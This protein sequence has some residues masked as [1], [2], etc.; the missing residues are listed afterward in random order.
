MSA[1][2]SR[3][4]QMAL[5]LTDDEVEQLPKEHRD[6]M[7]KFRRMFSPRKDGGSTANPFCLSDDTVVGGSALTAIRNR[8]AL[9]SSRRSRRSRHSRSRRRSGWRRQ[10]SRRRSRDG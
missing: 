5:K 7:L 10:R 2:Q 8:S 3:I 1:E 9:S 4:A 6:T